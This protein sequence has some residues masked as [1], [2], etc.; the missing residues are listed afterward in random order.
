[1]SLTHTELLRANRG[2]A[3]TAQ[4]NNVTGAVDQEPL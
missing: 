4:T 2:A 1:M 3:Q